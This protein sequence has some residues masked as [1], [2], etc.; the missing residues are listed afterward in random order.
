MLMLLVME[1]NIQEAHKG[2]MANSFLFVLV[3]CGLVVLSMVSMCMGCQVQNDQCQS[4]DSQNRWMK[5]SEN[6]WEYHYV[7]VFTGTFLCLCW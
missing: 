4:T 3:A 1:R 2:V 5:I 7:S 6:D